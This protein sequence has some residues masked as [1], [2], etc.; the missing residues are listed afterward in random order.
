MCCYNIYREGTRFLLKKIKEKTFTSHIS[1]SEENLVTYTQEMG[2]VNTFHAAEWGHC[3]W[4]N[5]NDALQYYISILIR[6]LIHNPWNETRFYNS[7][8]CYRRYFCDTWRTST[9]YETL[10]RHVTHWSKMKNEKMWPGILFV[11][12]IKWHLWSTLHHEMLFF[13]SINMHKWKIYFHSTFHTKQC[14][15]ITVHV[16]YIIL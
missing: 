1:Q 11:K 13:Y 14:S 5:S 7:M 10:L 15:S 9:E 8:A 6:L 3:I 4:N 2:C 16:A 12:A